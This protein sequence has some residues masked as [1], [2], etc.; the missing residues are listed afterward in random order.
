[1]RGTIVAGPEGVKEA[2][3]VTRHWCK[4][5]QRLSLAQVCRPCNDATCVLFL[6][7]GMPKANENL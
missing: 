6:V 3:A 2:T 5:T 7:Y 4:V 1:M